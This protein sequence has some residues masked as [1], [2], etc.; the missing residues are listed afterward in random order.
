MS[1]KKIGKNI[2][3][4]YEDMSG[5]NILRNKQGYALWKGRGH[6]VVPEL[7]GNSLS[8]FLINMDRH[9]YEE[10]I[11]NC[12]KVAFNHYNEWIFEEIIKGEE[13]P[14]FDRFDVLF[15]IRSN[16]FGGKCDTYYFYDTVY[17][18]YGFSSKEELENCFDL[19]KSVTNKRPLEKDN[20]IVDLE[21]KL[22]TMDDFINEVGY[23]K[24]LMDINFFGKPTY[25]FQYD[26]ALE[27]L[28]AI[29][30]KYKYLN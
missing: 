1:Y 30:N 27:Y 29:R 16:L 3:V 26:M 5:W 17:K 14:F 23:C 10:G 24:K 9:C 2:E 11:R 28:L 20:D 13:E 25:H 21:K 12:L 22:T 7:V 15:L 18:C 4:L 6:K 8:F 19:G